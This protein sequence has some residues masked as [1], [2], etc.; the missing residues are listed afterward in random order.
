MREDQ[1]RDLAAKYYLKT[2]EF[3]R[4]VCIGPIKN[5]AILPNWPWEMSEIN[6][7]AKKTYYEVLETARILGFSVK[8]LRGA[9]Q[10]HRKDLDLS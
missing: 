2:E 10:K 6:E 8:E 3:D 1:L 4:K 5:G 7:N 9:I